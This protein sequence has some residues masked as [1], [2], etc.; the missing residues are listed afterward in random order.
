MPS[1]GLRLTSF[2]ISAQFSRGLS[3]EADAL[4]SRQTRGRAFRS[5]SSVPYPRPFNL[6]LRLL[7][8]KPQL[9]CCLC[10]TCALLLSSLMTLSSLS[11]HSHALLSAHGSDAGIAALANRG[12]SSAS[13][14][15][16]VWQHWAG[17]AGQ[18][19]DLLVGGRKQYGRQTPPCQFTS[20]STSYSTSLSGLVGLFC[21]YMGLV[22]ETGARNVHLVGWCFMLICRKAP[23]LQYWCM[24]TPICKCRIAL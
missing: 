18:C 19:R 2:S 12:L 24:L 6:F 14:T 1:L 7:P 10:G 22:L 11:S 23:G 4:G 5:H 13:C 20:P 9:T 17:A 15:A 21:H 16:P 8:A 3:L